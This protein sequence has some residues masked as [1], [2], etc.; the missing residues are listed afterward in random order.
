MST[1]R[2]HKQRSFSVLDNHP[3]EDMALSWEALG[4]LTYLLSKPDDWRIQIQHLINLERGAGRDKLYGILKCLEDAGYLARRREQ[5]PDGKFT[6]VR[7]LYESPEFNPFRLFDQPSTDFQ[8]MAPPSPEKPYTDEPYTAQPYT[9]KPTLLN[10]EVP[11][12][13]LPITEPPKREGEDAAGQHA[14]QT[15][16]PLPLEEEGDQILLLANA[17]AETCGLSPIALAAMTGKGKAKWT[18][19]LGYARQ[20]ATLTLPPDW[21]DHPAQAGPITPDHVRHFRDWWQRTKPIGNSDDDLPHP[22]Q[23]FQ[24]LS[25]RDAIAWITHRLPIPGVPVQSEAPSTPGRT[26]PAST[27]PTDLQPDLP[28]APCPSQPATPASDLWQ[29]V[30]NELQLSLQRPV[31]DNW[32]RGT[33]G[34]ALDDNTLTVSV[35]SP[36]A[37]EWLEQ[38]MN[39]MIKLRVQRIA[40]KPLSVE[41]QIAAHA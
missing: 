31:Y 1:I 21:C 3:I 16:P 32:L 15:P 22:S 28:P 30:L 27:H 4:V 40:E 35:S 37:Q 33:V 2:T 26:R 18:E 14:A 17:I 19:I 6:W 34:A 36:F 29:A 11:N 8:D 25:T 20:F 10:T 38:R 12:T 23:V 41:Y 5:G 7:E 24:R 13:D 39:G 9:V